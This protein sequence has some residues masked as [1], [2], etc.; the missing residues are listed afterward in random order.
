[1]LEFAKYGNNLGIP[2]VALSGWTAML[3]SLLA[4]IQRLAALLFVGMPQC[5]ASSCNQH[6][7]V[8]CPLRSTFSAAM[9]DAPVCA[10]CRD[11][12]MDGVPRPATSA[13]ALRSCFIFPQ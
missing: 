11:P 10:V 13:V 12:L 5:Q 8:Q 4:S 9:A 7:V 1:M 6:R 2:C 3:D